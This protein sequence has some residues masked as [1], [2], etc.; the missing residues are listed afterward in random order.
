MEHECNAFETIEDQT[1]KSPKHCNFNETVFR[2]CALS[3][4]WEH[5]NLSGA[6]FED[7]AV[8]AEYVN[9]VGV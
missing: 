5:D 8:T 2:R 7:C 4:T 6:V 3:G 1:I 9:C